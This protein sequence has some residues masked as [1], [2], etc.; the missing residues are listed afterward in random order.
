MRGIFVHDKELAACGVGCHGARHGQDALRVLQIILKT[1]G[2]E[3]SPNGISRSSHAAA[4]RVAPLQHE[5]GDHPVEDRSVVK[6]LL[7]E[8]N[9]IM[10][11][12]RCDFRV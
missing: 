5:A 3:L 4:V 8:G 1:V 9:E 7:N 12:V 10:D 11:G 6:A 2:A